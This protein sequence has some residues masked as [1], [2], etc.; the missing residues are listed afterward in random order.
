MAHRR[1]GGKE[2]RFHRQLENLIARGHPL[3][4]VGVA[5]IAHLREE[6]RT[7]PARLTTDHLAVV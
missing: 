1:H 2:D 7:G 3:L 6:D 4:L 5:G